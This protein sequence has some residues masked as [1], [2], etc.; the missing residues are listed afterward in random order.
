MDRN[1]HPEQYPGLSDPP[2]VSVLKKKAER[3]F[4]VYSKARH[5]CS[6]QLDNLLHGGSSYEL[7][8]TSGGEHI[9]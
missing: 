7:V 5:S 8:L 4:P 2:S 1:R 6:T 9:I 3:L